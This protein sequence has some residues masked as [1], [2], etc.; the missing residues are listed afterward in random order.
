MLTFSDLMSI[1]T[2]AVVIALFFLTA[3]TLNLRERA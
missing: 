3:W 2:F 1:T